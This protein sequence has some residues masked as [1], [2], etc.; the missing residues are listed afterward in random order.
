MK[1]SALITFLLVLAACCLAAP[2]AAQ[3][4]TTSGGSGQ[5]LLNLDN[6]VAV[7]GYDVVAY[8]NQDRARRGNKRL[9]QRLGMAT[10]YFAS[11]RNRYQFQTDAPKYQPQFGGYCTLAMA[12]GR[13]EDI[14]PHAFTIYRGKLYLFRDDNAKAAFFQDPDHIIHQATANYF[15]IARDR[16]QH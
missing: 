16:R 9:K 1:K 11:S 8:F 13:L 5:A 3:P 2:A 14:D 7:H 6:T 10:Y 12:L 4:P 15:E